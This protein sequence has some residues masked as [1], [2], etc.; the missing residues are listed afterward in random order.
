MENVMLVSN[1]RLAWSVNQ[2]EKRMAHSRY[3][4][5]TQILLMLFIIT[6]SQ[7]SETVQQFLAD[8][9]ANLLG[10]D[11]VLIQLK[12]LSSEE[13][14]TVDSLS[15]K[16]ALTQTIESTLTHKKQWQRVKLK[17][18]GQN[19]PLQGE[20]VVADSL[21]GQRIERLTGPEP[22]TIWLDSRLY[23][24]LNITIGE[25]LNIAGQS[26]RV[27]KILMHE[28]DRLMEGH[29]TAMRAMVN[30]ADMN[31][32]NF[33]QELIQHRYL[34]EV[35]ASQS[36]DLLTWQKENLPIAQ[37]HRRT[38]AHPLALFWKRVEN[39]LGLTSIILFF[40][41][42]IAIEK[43]TQI[44][45][46]KEQYFSAIC[47]SVGA[48]IMTV[49]QI[50]LFKWVIGLL[51]L[52]PIALIISACCHWLVVSWLTI[53][54][55]EISW[56]WHVWL[57]IKSVLSLVIIF[58]IFQAPVWTGLL[59]SSIAQL[60]NNTHSK[61]SKLVT[62]GSALAVLTLVALTFSDNGL[63]T[64]MVLVSML[65]SIILIVLTSWIALVVGEKATNRLSG[66]LPFALFMMRQRLVNKS[67]QILGVGLCA[68]LLLFTLMLM[69]DLGTT[70]SSYEREHNGNLLVTQATSKQMSDI[71]NW[72]QGNDIS[73]L[74]QKPFMYAKLIKVN[75]L[76]L[77]DYS[78][79][80]SEGMSTMKRS[81]RLH[82]SQHVPFNNRVVEG[83]WWQKTD[84]NWQQ[85]SIEEEVMTDLG[86]EIGD[87]VTFFVGQQS[88][89]FTIVASHVYTSGG[90]SITFWAQIPPSALNYIQA[91]HY[92]IASLELAE[93]QFSL[94]GQMW[95]KHPSLRM[96]SLKEMTESFD[97]MLAMLTH[98]VTGFSVI[99]ILLSTIVILATVNA[100]ESGEKKKNSV[101]MSF[102]FSKQTCLHLNLIEWIVTGVIAAIGAIGGTYIAGMLI[103]K[104]QF[105]LTYQPDFVWLF[106][107][108]VV[109]L[110]AVALLGLAASKN[111]LNSSIRE[112]MAEQ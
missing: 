3:L 67:T 11:V 61:V 64:T 73:I 9:M 42:A 40:M 98:A 92:S 22:G 89:E 20:L 57:S 6:L 63:L 97:K 93:S 72:T 104:S 83:D 32:L 86:L 81:I 66:L 35:S 111:S 56:Q 112:L 88:V 26:L 25:S 110:G 48:S 95:Q 70:F 101:I 78:V 34:F 15:N 39:F 59:K 23:S 100:L 80:P 10:A 47:M 108:L 53:T 71:Q 33:P 5:W 77:S 46:R 55:P 103:Y 91:P 94:L 7:T 18:V 41:A 24:G 65:I 29:S 79:K 12:P 99:I 74:Q 21:Q 76:K 36:K 69:K 27:A 17:A 102:G 82:W 54:F 2:Q 28:P 50:S 90:S 62:L 109:I 4:R 51:S 58:L 68:F 84:K 49:F 44:Q 31:K 13:T 85:V 19:Y 87:K 52:V 1:F 96:S 30:L 16:W 8:N 43:L 107:T 37:V 106:G 60:A 14:A 38:G 75:G 45:V 105:S